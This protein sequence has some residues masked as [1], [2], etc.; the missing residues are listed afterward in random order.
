MKSAPPQHLVFSPRGVEE[1]KQLR[2]R[3]SARGIAAASSES[4]GIWSLDAWLGSLDGMLQKLND[5]QDAFVF[6]TVEA[7]VPSGLISRPQRMVQWLARNTSSSPTKTQLDHI[8]DNVVDREFFDVANGIR[9]KLGLKWIVGVTGS[10]VA[11]DDGS[12]VYWN[13]FSSSYRRMVLA[14]T[15]DLHEFAKSSRQPFEAFLVTLIVTQLLVA[16]SPHLD[17]HR[18]RGCLFD[19]DQERVT[20]IDKINKPHVSSTCLRRIPPHYRSAAT[21]LIDVINSYRRSPK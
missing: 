11:G 5:A 13:H 19:Y 21:G 7:A 20:L 3:G 17:F 9:V 6:H 12:E 8:V 15:Y 10:M 18:N 2:P 16:A 14:S 4:V 1:A